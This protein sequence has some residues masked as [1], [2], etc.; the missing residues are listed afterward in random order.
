MWKRLPLT[1]RGKEN[2]ISKPVLIDTTYEG[3]NLVTI[4]SYP[5]VPSKTIDGGSSFG[6]RTS[7]AVLTEL[8]PNYM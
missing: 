3:N 8:A 5:D 6:R 7:G 1:G 4:S 2:Q